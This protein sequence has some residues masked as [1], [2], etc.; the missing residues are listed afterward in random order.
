[1]KMVYKYY[2]LAMKLVPTLFIY[3]LLFFITSCSDTT[4]PDN[5]VTFS[6]MVTLEGETDHSGVTI[7]LYKPVE[8]SVRSRMPMADTALTHQPGCPT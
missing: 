1:M 8:L 4:D 7:G 6:G 5:T 2:K 3:Y